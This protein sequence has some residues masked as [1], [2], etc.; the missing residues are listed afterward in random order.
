MLREADYVN[1][2]FQDITEILKLWPVLKESNGYDLI[3]LDFNKKYPEAKDKLLLGWMQFYDNIASLND[4][5]IFPEQASVNKKLLNDNLNLSDDSK[6]IIQFTLL[7]YFIRPKSNKCK[8]NKPATQKTK[9]NYYKADVNDA[10]KS[11]LVHVEVNFYD[12]IYFYFI[13]NFIC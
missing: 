8:I 4:S 7:P 11:L 2:N 10:A 6:N 12:S 9:A 1:K 13:L 3:E 5:K